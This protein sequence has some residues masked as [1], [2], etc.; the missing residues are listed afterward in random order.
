[1]RVSGRASAEMSRSETVNVAKDTQ[2][3]DAENGGY[4]LYL[5]VSDEA[6]PAVSDASVV[7]LTPKSS[8]ADA[9]LAAITSAGLTAAD[10]RTRT[11]FIA[12]PG[13]VERAAAVYAAVA[14]FA[15]RHLDVSDLDVVTDVRSIHDPL[16]FPADTPR[17]ESAPESM[18]FSAD[19]VVDGLDAASL[20]LVHF[21]KKVVLNASVSISTTLEALVMV[22]ALR[23]RGPVEKFPHLLPNGTP[24]PAGDLDTG[25]VDLDGLRRAGAQ[26]RRDRRI[27]DRA[28]VVERLALSPRAVRLA[29]AAALPLEEV[30]TRLGSVRDDATG[31]Y[32]CPRPERHRNGD[33]TPSARLAE[34]GFRCFRCDAEQVDALRLVMDVRGLAPDAAADWLLA[35]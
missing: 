8:D 29:A 19:D 24:L 31:F 15:G 1:V 11:L 5:Y 22:A 3:R 14:G 33:A 20:P 30:L 13:P 6:L 17:P 28:T 35:H 2:D 10:L 23:R 9:V 34:H 25:L 27:D 32:R 18:L 12:G 26:L 7:N 4:Q 21:A 16:L